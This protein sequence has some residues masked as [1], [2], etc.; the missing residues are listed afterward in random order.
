MSWNKTKEILPEVGKTVIAYKKNTNDFLFCSMN[1]F[2]SWLT[3][4]GVY[5]KGTITHWMY[6]PEIPKEEM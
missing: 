2:G 6:L 1:E 3:R 5:A 4:N